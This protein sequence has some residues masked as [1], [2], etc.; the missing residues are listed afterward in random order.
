M[1]NGIRCRHI[2]LLIKLWEGKL[3]TLKCVSNITSTSTSQEIGL[4]GN[5]FF[6]KIIFQ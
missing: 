6:L 2:E 3:K 4:L 5:H 1:M